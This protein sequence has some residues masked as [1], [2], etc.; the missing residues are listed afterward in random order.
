VYLS[1]KKHTKIALIGIQLLWA[2]WSNKCIA[3]DAHYWTHQYGTASTLFGGAV[4]GSVVD[5]STTYYN[6]AGMAMLENPAILL[7]AKVFDLTRVHFENGAGQHEDLSSLRFASAPDLAAGMISLDRLK[8]NRL[9]WSFLTRQK[10]KIR[11]KSSQNTFKDVFST[12]PGEER[13]VNESRIDQSLSEYWT[14][15]SWATKLNK[16]IGIGITQ[17]IAYRYQRK[18]VQI[19]SEA[20]L[21]DQVASTIQA[22]EYKYEN[23]RT[24]GKLGFIYENSPVT[25]GISVTTPSLDLYGFGSAIMNNTI[26]GQDTDGDGEID[27]TLDFNHQKDLSAVYRSSWTVGMGASYQIDKATLHFSTEWYD[28]IRS[29]EIMKIKDFRSASSGALVSNK[30]KYQLEEII[31]YGI[32]L[33]YNFNEMVAGYGSIITDYSAIIPEKN[34]KL[35]ISNWDIYHVTIG[36]TINV[37][38]LDFTLGLGFAFGQETNQQIVNY[39]N[40]HESNRLVGSREEADVTFTRMKIIFG[41]SYLF[42]D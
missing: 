22:Q 8:E 25:F 11:L 17:Y 26:T 10:F 2:L 6:P 40:V 4:I 3:Q 5:L 32:G 38:H 41:F 36:S 35:T 7:S 12:H 9:A 27:L 14:G 23:Y 29:Y 37:N 1:I 19:I 21:E 18:R 15:I 24:L 28:A 20:L 33:Q 42:G 31:N 13:F 16:N 39:A 30:L 34:T